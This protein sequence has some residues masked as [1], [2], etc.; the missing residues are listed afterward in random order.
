ML[1]SH[2]MQIHEMILN[3]YICKFKLKKW[4]VLFCS[5]SSIYRHRDRQLN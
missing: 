5:T 4:P 2:I 3:D 1:E